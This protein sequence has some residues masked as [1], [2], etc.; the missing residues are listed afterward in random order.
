MTSKTSTFPSPPGT[1]RSTNLTTTARKIHSPPSSSAS[2]ERIM[3][4]IA[5][6]TSKMLLAHPKG[7]RQLPTPPGVSCNP[8][9]RTTLNPLLLPGR[10]DDDE[11]GE[12][13]VAK[14]ELGQGRQAEALHHHGPQHPDRQRSGAR[15]GD[16]HPRLLEPVAEPADGRHDDAAKLGREEEVQ[17]PRG[18]VDVPGIRTFRQSRPHNHHHHH[19]DR[20]SVSQGY[21]CSVGQSMFLGVTERDSVSSVKGRTRSFKVLPQRDAPLPGRQPLIEA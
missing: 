19:H 15:R 3:T 1:T 6:S 11:A 7:P 20:H 21:S 9:P 4:T 14:V 18:A 5:R 8:P 13:H 10:H 2:E 17:R 12:G 16:P